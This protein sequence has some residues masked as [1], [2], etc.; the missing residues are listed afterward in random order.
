MHI[1]DENVA[2]RYLHVGCCSLVRSSAVIVVEIIII[3]F[4]CN[5]SI[6]NSTATYQPS[7]SLTITAFESFS[8]KGATY[9]YIYIHTFIYCW[10]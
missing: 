1:Y 7:T 3:I 8:N 9:N 10:A 6:F 4:D 2:S 5:M